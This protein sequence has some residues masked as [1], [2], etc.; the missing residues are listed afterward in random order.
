MKL[1]SI[2]SPGLFKSSLKRFWPLWLAGLVGRVLLFDVPMY[3][4]VA[5]I[6]RDNPTLASRQESAES[7]WSIMGLFAWCYGLVGSLTVALAL[8]EHLFDARSATFMGSLPVRRP[9]VFATVA[10][11]GLFVLLALPALAIAFLLP[12]QVQ[13]SL[14]CL[15]A[16]W[17]NAWV[18]VKQLHE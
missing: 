9:A 14:I 2:L 6:V 16:L 5:S 13:T 17:Q 4:A 10:L 8:H 3:G 15:A 1:A 18:P 11:A 7:L 12:L